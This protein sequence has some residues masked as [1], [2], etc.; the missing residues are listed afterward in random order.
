MEPIWWRGSQGIIEL[1]I[2]Y[3]KLTKI[4]WTLR[5]LEV[6]NTTQSG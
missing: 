5:R 4:N 6:G 2:G 3:R 1:E